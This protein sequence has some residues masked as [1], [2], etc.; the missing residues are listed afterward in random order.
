M[1][2]PLNPGIPI[3]KIGTVADKTATTI[4]PLAL[5]TAINV[6]VGDK[7][8]VPTVVRDGQ[9]VQPPPLNPA[10]VGDLLTR[11]QPITRI[12]IPRIM[13]QSIPPGTRVQKGTPVDIVLLPVSDID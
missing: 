2:L 8:V 11:L 10:K 13:S 7:T 9:E 5:K 1:A 6:D 3:V 12:N 4:N